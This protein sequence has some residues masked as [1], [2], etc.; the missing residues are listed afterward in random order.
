MTPHG[1]ARDTSPMAIGSI[2]DLTLA[3]HRRGRHRNDRHRQRWLYK[4]YRN[5]RKAN[6]RMA[7][8]PG[9]HLPLCAAGA[10]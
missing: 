10:L 8:L 1:S 7:N 6:F 4:S 5:E 2:D 3:N 9:I